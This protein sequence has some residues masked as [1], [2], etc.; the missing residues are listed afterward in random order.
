MSSNQAIIDRPSIPLQLHYL[1]NADL[2][3]HPKLCLEVQ[4]AV[5]TSSC[6]TRDKGAMLYKQT[7]SGKS[8]RPCS[9]PQA[10]QKQRQHQNAIS[11]P[12]FAA[13]T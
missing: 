2:L 10:G 6:K 7:Q 12:C 5:Q 4:A 13:A 11:C 1:K 8:K 3:L 9:A